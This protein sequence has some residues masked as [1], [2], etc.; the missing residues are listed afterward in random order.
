MHLC[1]RYVGRLKRSEYKVCRKLGGHKLP[2]TDDDGLG[3]SCLGEA[4]RQVWHELEGSGE[5]N[6]SKRRLLKLHVCMKYARRGAQYPAII[7]HI[8]S[9][10]G[11]CLLQ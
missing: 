3:D 7:A 8:V 11:S 5:F 2:T 4:Q 10:L 1:G 9:Y 6:L